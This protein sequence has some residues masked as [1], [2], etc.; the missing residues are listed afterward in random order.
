[1]LLFRCM[2]VGTKKRAHGKVRGP[3]D[4]LRQL[5][6]PPLPW[7]APAARRGLAEVLLTLEVIVVRWGVLPA[8]SRLHWFGPWRGAIK[9]TR[10]LS[11]SGLAPA[12]GLE[13]VT[14]R[15]TAACST[16]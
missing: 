13:P 1:M 10:A 2:R 15:L 7:V 16:N 3:V 6:S 9:K 12:T 11:R 4:W 5:D 8:Y 14:R